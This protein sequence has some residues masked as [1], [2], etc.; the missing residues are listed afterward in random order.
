MI[1]Y[2]VL[3]RKLLIVD[4]ELDIITSLKKILERHEF[5]VDGFTDSVEAL[6]KFKPNM[7]DLTILDIRMPKMNGFELYREIRKIDDKCRICFISAF[8]LYY[9]ELRKAFPEL[10]PKSFVKKPIRV[11]DF[12][13][14]INVELTKTG[15]M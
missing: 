11:A 5:E 4:D 14:R 13:E 3:H 9:D 1:N 6:S 10:D 12:I 8:E 2:L 7:Y 15:S